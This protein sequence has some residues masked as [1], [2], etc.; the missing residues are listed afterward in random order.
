MFMCSC[1]SF[2]VSLTLFLSE[3][4]RRAEERADDL[5]SQLR[6][7]EEARKKAE[8]DASCIEDLR[9]R[10]KA[11]EDALSD[12][13]V[14][15]VE[16]ENARIK[17]FETQSRRFSSTYILSFAFPFF[18]GSSFSRLVLIK[19]C[20]SSAG[21]MGEHYTLGEESDDH[22]LDALDILELNCDL[23]RKCLTSTRDALK[24]IFPH[25]FPRETQPEIFSQLTHH[26][27]AD[28]DIALANR[29]ASLKIGVEGTIALVAATGQE[30]DWVKAVAPQGL[31]SKKWTAFVKGAKLYST[32]LISFL[33]PKSSAFASTTKTEVK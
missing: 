26:F 28:E 23:A 7:S 14:K 10:L 11:A 24:R 21:K 31:N 3:S 16:L 22:L 2:A 30:V 20:F 19:S 29:Q 4:L 1:I 32:K 33:D 6:A 13:E 25:F 9:L 27:L 15:Q 17:R 18:L 5:E 8:K 12:K